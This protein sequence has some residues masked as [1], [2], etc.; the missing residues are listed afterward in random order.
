MIHENR[1]NMVGVNF[2]TWVDVS[3]V[4]LGP[5]V[6]R[7]L[8]QRCAPIALLACVYG[9]AINTILIVNILPMEGI[10]SIYTDVGIP[11]LV[12]KHMVNVEVHDKEAVGWWVDRDVR[13]VKLLVVGVEVP[14]LVVLAHEPGH[15]ED[16][17]LLIR[18]AAKIVKG[19]R[20]VA[21]LHESAILK[22]HLP[23]ND[24]GHERSIGWLLA[25]S[26]DSAILTRRNDTFD[27]V[28]LE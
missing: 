21:D 18:G 26:E 24:G 11:A 12:G 13:A 22:G 17:L 1:I 2:V 19:R 4:P 5:T 23:V 14:D 25:W 10:V 16:A 27:N 3:I 7:T 28:N 20:R 15:L 6:A 8:H 9:I